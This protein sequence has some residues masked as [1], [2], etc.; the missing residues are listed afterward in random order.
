[1]KTKR[2]IWIVI[3]VLALYAGSYLLLRVR[4]VEVWARDGRPYLIIPSGSPWLYYLY[5][6][7]MYLD[8]AITGMRF[9]IGPHRETSHARTIGGA[10]AKQGRN[11][12]LETHS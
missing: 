3:V 4:C 6:P 1:V 5:R 8:A 9:H 12:R 11:C 7:L 10:H 2:S